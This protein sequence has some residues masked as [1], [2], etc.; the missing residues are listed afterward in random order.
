MLTIWLCFKQGFLQV[1]RFSYW[2]IL[3]SP[4]I[5]PFVKWESFCH[6]TG[7]MQF[8][9]TM[10]C[11]MLYP[12][13]MIHGIDTLFITFFA[14]VP[15]IEPLLSA[16][17]TCYAKVPGRGQGEHRSFWDRTCRLHLIAA[18]FGLKVGMALFETKAIV[19]GLLSNDA[20]FLTTPKEGLTKTSSSAN[21]VKRQSDDD[22]LAATA[23]LVG[24]GRIL[25]LIHFNSYVRS[26]HGAF[27]LIM[28][29]T[30]GFSLV[31]VNMSFMAEKHGGKHSGRMSRMLSFSLL[32]FLTVFLWTNVS[33]VE[34]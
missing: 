7:A 10:I 27:T 23:T 5:S 25:T 20:T 11:I 21:S 26:L 24:M 16:I 19:E 4:K 33:V 6:I 31:W 15:S 14:F 22:F 3:T 29:I 30:I 17:V 2:D 34:V 18:Y 1:F 13:L 12:F 9:A 28:N 32:L 8:P